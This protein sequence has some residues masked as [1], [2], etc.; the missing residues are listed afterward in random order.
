VARPSLQAAWWPPLTRGR[1]HLAKAELKIE[2]ARA[3]PGVEVEDGDQHQGGCGDHLPDVLLVHVVVAVVGHLV[4]GFFHLLLNVGV[5]WK[6]PVDAFATVSSS[7]HF[8]APEVLYNG[9]STKYNKR[10]KDTREEDVDCIRDQP[11]KQQQ[12]GRSTCSEKESN[13][14]GHEDHQPTLVTV[15]ADKGEGKVGSH[16]E[17]QVAHQ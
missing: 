13:V 14:T 1:F 17:H 15:L 8:G 7:Q 4:N 12:P 2:G 9:D 6:H 3:E 10:C 16:E 11:R 5:L